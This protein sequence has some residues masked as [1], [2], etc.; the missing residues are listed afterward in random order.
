MTNRRNWLNEWWHLTDLKSQC[1][2]CQNKNNSCDKCMFKC[3][4]NELWTLPTFKASL[5]GESASGPTLVC[6]SEMTA[7]Y[8]SQGWGTHRQKNKSAQHADTL[9]PRI[10]TRGVGGAGGRGGLPDFASCSTL[11]FCVTAGPAVW[12][13]NIWSLCVCVRASVCMCARALAYCCVKNWVTMLGSE[14]HWTEGPRLCDEGRYRTHSH[15][16]G[17]RSRALSTLST[18]RLSS[19]HALHQGTDQETQRLK[20]SL[21]V[22][23]SSLSLRLLIIRILT[24]FFWRQ[25]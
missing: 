13:V 12:H 21:I 4:A 7:Q 8:L 14:K 20:A 19:M 5:G 22:F 18:G 15:R 9:H 2:A 16:G 6:L 10:H 23:S 1:S 11:H 24:A 17:I 25:T 3:A